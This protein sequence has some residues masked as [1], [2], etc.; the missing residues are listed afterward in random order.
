MKRFFAVLVVIVLLAGCSQTVQYTNDLTGKWIIYKLIMN[1]TDVT[2]RDQDSIKNYSITFTP[3]GHY[4]EQNA[5]PN[6]MGVVTDTTYQI[7]TW[8]FQ[9][10]LEYLVL[11]DTAMNVR[12]YTI[13]NLQSNHVELKRNGEDRYMRK[14]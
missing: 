11:T 7:G 10:S 5:V 14:P 2:S 6:S 13:F 9:N 3:D 4:V 12:T 8:A 1:N